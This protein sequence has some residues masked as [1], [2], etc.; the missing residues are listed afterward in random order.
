MKVQGDQEQISA[1]ITHTG[2]DTRGTAVGHL[3]LL[4]LLRTWVLIQ[5]LAINY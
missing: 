3:W 4:S 2:A 5:Q 1:P